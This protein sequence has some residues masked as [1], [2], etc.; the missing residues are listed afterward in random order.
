[1]SI[2]TSCDPN[3]KI[4]IARIKVQEAMNDYRITLNNYAKLRTEY[5]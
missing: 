4:E 5:D 2:E 3:E 1:M